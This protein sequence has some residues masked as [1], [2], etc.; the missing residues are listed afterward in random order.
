MGTVTD[1]TG[2]VIPG[3]A[4]TIKNQGTGETRAG[5]TG[6]QGEFTFTLLPPGNY[7]VAIEA[8]GFKSYVQSDINLS[9]GQ[10]FRIDAG[11]SV[12]Q[13]SETVQVNA[14][15]TPALQTDSSTL[16]AV[17]SEH[18]VEDL[19]LNG[20]N[21]LQL[22]QL[23]P[24]ANEGT[25]HGVNGNDPRP[26]T[27][28]LVVNAQSETAN[29]YM[30]DGMDS[31]DRI[32]GLAGVRPSVDAI[33]EVNTL[34]GQYTADLGRTAGAV[35][36]VVTK[37][38]ANSIHGSAFDFLR[39]DVLDAKGY[40]AVGTKSPPFRMNQFGGS[41]G[42]PIRK[43]KTFFFADYQ[44]LR[45]LQ[46]TPS[47][48]TVP[49][50]QEETLQSD[51]GGQY[52]D[53]SD[54]GGG[55]VYWGQEYGSS[56]VAWNYY[57][58]FPAPTIPNATVNNYVTS[59]PVTQ[60]G[61][62]FDARI[63]QIFNDKNSLFGRYSYNGDTQWNSGS[64]PAI[65]NF[66]LNQGLDGMTQSTINGTI[67]PGAATNNPT[68]VQNIQVNFTHAFNSATML[69]LVGGYTRIRLFTT[70]ADTQELGNEFGIPNANLGD[71]YTTGLPFANLGPAGYAS[72]GDQTFTPNLIQDG[73][74]QYM[75]TLSRT[76][77]THNLKLG[78]SVL[79][80]DGNQLQNR[81]G[82]GMYIFA[83]PA[84][85][86]P[87]FLDGWGPFGGGTP[88]T[89]LRANLMQVQDLRTWEWAGYAAD[90]W[91][92]TRK[93]TF[94]LGVRY[95]IFTP[96][97]E[98]LNRIS[99][100]DPDKAT[101]NY[102]GLNGIGKT[103][104]INTDYLNLSPRVGVAY[105]V[106][107][108]TVIRGGYAISY[109]NDMAGT[110]IYL[111]NTPEEISWQGGNGMDQ[112]MPA[113]A[114]T[115]PQQVL[116]NP[117]AVTGAL[118]GID[119][120]IK[121]PY[122]EQMSLNVEQQVKGF[123]ATLGYVG[124]LTKRQYQ[125]QNIDQTAPGDPSTAGGPSPQGAPGRLNTTPY[126]A[127]FPGV[128]ENIQ[129]LMST[130]SSNYNAL[131]ASLERRYGKNLALSANYTWAHALNDTMSMDGRS[132]SEGWG[133]IPDNTKGWKNIPS[134]VHAI[135]YGNSDFDV[136]HRIAAN[137]NYQIPLG[138]SLKGAAGELAKGW[139]LNGIF[140]FMTGEP[141]SVV[142]GVNGGQEGT[143]TSPP[144]NQ[145]RPNI[146]GNWKL[147]NRTPAEWFNVS[148]FELQPAGTAGNER[149]NQL[150]G[151]VFRHFDLSLGKQFAITE[152]KSLQFRAESFNITNTTN[153]DVPVNALP[154]HPGPSNF[155]T[156]G[157]TRFSPRQ[158]Q[159]ALKLLF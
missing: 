93:L 154:S 138:S 15:E 106:R 83:G 151:P 141:F 1:N 70:M 146:V 98:K 127:E 16:Q 45:Q 7:K 144:N 84:G 67:Y 101:I 135:E 112:G 89:G 31:N 108:G 77:G 87:A 34:T 58:L 8:K 156:I 13:A 42:G 24:G 155:G 52:Y 145:D 82:E 61:D 122:V 55:K 118:T 41:I 119:R 96:Y 113:P 60:N 18:A 86:L 6:Q 142:S 134:Q 85:N 71:P 102:A 25:N 95:S 147:S 44:G 19:P 158:I 5:S 126:Y 79:R 17:V 73:T 123:V 56:P 109:F 130:G 92:A 129:L 49:T 4:V 59:S 120:N 105:T 97:T 66:V 143:N 2:G 133:N 33:Q 64:L 28:N 136:R 43:D 50:A 3:A 21:F 51:S 29:N 27:E 11:L 22:A 157:N 107:D 53:F 38:G 68:R 100:F 23:A 69:E 47:L 149:R 150:Y 35:V 48:Q 137:A 36:N 37:A 91:R 57:R 26:N 132:L 104:G 159:F 10:R 90:N 103:A 124:I 139:A 152:G 72:I 30:I 39:N 80:A 54:N 12:G 20:R 40:F 65:Q 121:T 32:W 81:W 88:A 117:A 116:A 114:P 74:Q 131:Q 78:F 14:A 62:D 115:T 125:D 75:A 99:S 153:F 110:G 148:A 76:Q 9:V 94:N 46:V 128:N 111:K 140:V 63:D